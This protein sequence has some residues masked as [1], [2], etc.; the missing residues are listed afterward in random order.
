[1]ADKNYTDPTAPQD[2]MT[3]L[4][5]HVNASLERLDDDPS[6]ETTAK[7]LKEIASILP[8]PFYFI[9][10]QPLRTGMTLKDM[11][12]KLVDFLKKTGS[13]PLIGF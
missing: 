6:P 10:Q 11:E 1:M 13:K 12:Q 2:L 8:V 9:G 5:K 4:T 7:V 3:I